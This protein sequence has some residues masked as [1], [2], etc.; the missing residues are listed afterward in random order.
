MEESFREAKNCTS[1][2]QKQKNSTSLVDECHFH[3]D[4]A[5][6]VARDE[7]RIWKALLFIEWNY[8]SA[9][10][11]KEIT[12]S[13]SVST[14]TR[15]R[16]F[17]TIVGTTPVNYLPDYRLQKAAEELQHQGKRTVSEIAYLC[18]FTDASYFNRYFRHRN[19]QINVIGRP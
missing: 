19:H 16:L 4:T 17:S 8:G 11:L 7:L 10:T 14:S 3:I 2:V 18:G 6:G 15:L 9:V 13:D 1:L 5:V 12:G